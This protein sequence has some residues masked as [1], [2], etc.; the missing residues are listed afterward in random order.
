MTGAVVLLALVSAASP[1]AARGGCITRLP[2]SISLPSQFAADYHKVVRIRVTSRGPRIRSV[3]A[4][5]YTFAGEPLGRSRKVSALGSGRV[6]R[7]KTRFPV[8]GGRYTLIVTGEPNASRSCGPKQSHHVITFRDCFQQ[9]PLAFPHPPGGFA[10]DY[11]DV[12]SVEV[13]TTGPIIRRIHGSL[14]D[15]AGNQFG[16][17]D[18]PFLVGR[19]TLN[20]TLSQPLVAGQ[21]TVFL[22]GKVKQPASCGD[23]DAKLILTF[24]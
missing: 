12:L 20:L 8:Q 18:L 19:A 14:S 5:L 23:K 21:Y 1:A 11:G 10:K 24:Q 15:F 13:R 16:V 9:L 4:Q 7:I 22:T 2:V 3:S 6:L 17:G